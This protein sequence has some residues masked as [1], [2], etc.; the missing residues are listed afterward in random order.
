MSNKF[1]Q[2]AQNT[3]NNAL[4]IARELGHTYIGSEHILLGLLSEG[5]SIASRLLTTRGADIKK[6]RSTVIDIS[7]VG[8]RSQVTPADMTPRAKK[9]IEASAAESQRGGNDYIGTEHI[10]YALMSEKDSV[11]VRLL[12]AEGIPASEVISD[13]NAFI[14]ASTGRSDRREPRQE[15]KGACD[16]KLRIKGAPMLSAHGRDLT[17]SAREGKLD[18]LIGREKETE[19]LIQIL[20]RRTKNNPCLIGE[21]GVGK[22]AVVEGLAERIAARR[23]PENLCDRRIVT[24][25][26]PSMIAGA[27]YRGEFEDRMKTVMEEVEKNPDII[28]FIDEIHVIIGAG[29]AEGAVDAANIIKPALARGQLQVIGATTVSEYRT[30]IEK[31]P[32]LERRFQSVYVGEPT[33][34]EA[35]NILS[36]LREKYEEHHKLSISDEALSAAVSLSVRYIPDRFLPDKAIDLIDEAASRVRIRKGA[37]HPTLSLLESQLA[38]LSA[39]KDRAVEC[40]DF[41]L[42]ASVRDREISLRRRLSEEQ[43]QTALVSDADALSVTRADV[44]DIVTEWTGIPVSD[45]LADE[46]EKLL[47]LEDRLSRRVIGQSEAIRAVSLAIRRGRIGLKDPKRPTGSFIFIGKTGVGKTKL[48]TA[49]ACEIFGSESA[50][51]R[52][53]MSEYMEKHSVSR[54]IGSPPGYVG[55]EDGG[56]L[57]ERIRRRPY[58]VVLFDE[59]E[60]AHPD[61]FNILLQILEDGSL[62]DS[63]GR[64]ADFSNSIII[65]TSNAGAEGK[66][67]LGF[68]SGKDSEEEQERER[69]DMLG[70]LR[71]GF[72]PEFLNRVDDIIVFRS[73]DVGDIEEIAS[74]MLS[75]VS[76]RAKGLDVELSFDAQ[77]AKFLS[78]RSFSQSYGARQ[79]RRNVTRFIEDPLSEEF[80]RGSV[81]RGDSVLARVGDESIIFDSL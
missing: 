19:R 53:D 3:L 42:A 26:I 72:R 27:K 61:V 54:L 64:R 6:L 44:A 55:Y 31:D 1:T 12:E 32:A 22:T 33:E 45:L 65:M 69:S 71:S 40:Q 74:G 9:V 76:E 25:N 81:K 52:L 67:V 13:L 30:R 43:R 38:Q 78:E 60:K 20:S 39:E 80:L 63:Q 56:Q 11:A 15:S 75:K 35:L 66:R 5:D 77:V 62:T 4:N 24:L 50:L 51:I 70:A 36:G 8:S 7:G 29:A 48:S 28:L 34:V 2:K 16:D 14:S 10:L 21:P 47:S 57:T 41:E 46:N 37:P 18:P 73:L 17:A 68:T 58:S 23:V 49:I 79:V 59:I